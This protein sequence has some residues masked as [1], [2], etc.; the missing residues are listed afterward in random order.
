MKKIIA[1]WKAF[2]KA[3]K[4]ANIDFVALNNEIMG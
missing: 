4:E 2:R 1:L 3:F